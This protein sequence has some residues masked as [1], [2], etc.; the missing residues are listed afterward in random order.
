M[1][2]TSLKKFELFRGIPDFTAP[3]RHILVYDICDL[4]LA[5]EVRKSQIA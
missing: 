3:L 4:S 2:N 1:T 5:K